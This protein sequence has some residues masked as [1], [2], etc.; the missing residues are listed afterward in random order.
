MPDERKMMNIPL[1]HASAFLI[2]IIKLFLLC[3][4]LWSTA[5]DGMGAVS[6]IMELS[7][8]AHTPMTH[9]INSNKNKSALTYINKEIFTLNGKEETTRKIS[10]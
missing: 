2:N 6:S 1:C 5:T 8:R 4:V 10:V 3:S 9:S 7:H